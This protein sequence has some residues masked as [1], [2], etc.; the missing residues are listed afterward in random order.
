MKKLPEPLYVTRYGKAYVGD[1]LQLLDC[2]PD[3]FVDLVITSP[4][5]ALQR[6]KEYGNRD[7]DEYVDWFL[8]FAAKV[9]RVLKDT[10][11]FV[12]DLGGAYRKGRPV[13]SLYNYRVLLRLCDELGWNLA[14]EFFWFNP[15]KLPSPIEWVNK[16][17]IR[18]KDAVNTIWWLSKTDFPKADI[19]RVLVPYSDRMKRLLE[20]SDKYYSPKKRPSGHDISERFAEDRGGA[21][22]AN[23][24]QIPNTESNSQY[25]RCC[26]MVGVK[27]HPARFPQKL[28]QFFIQF[29]TD[30]GDT[31]LDIFAGSNTTGAAAEEL[32]RHW[33][34][35]EL[36]QSYLAAS[37]FR[38]MPEAEKEMARSL[39]ARLCV[40]GAANIVIPQV[41]QERLFDERAEYIAGTDAI[42]LSE[43][44]ANREDSTQ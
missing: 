20:N 44:P 3:Q 27:A 34:A 16:R 35:F 11:S 6:K 32:G 13:R 26:K 23:L 9:R 38:F 4:P 33:I 21:I 1:A 18:A 15:A 41:L 42:E 36:E 22:P 37:A 43:E 29:L 14:E 30:A 17:K 12:I 24:L 2:L 39:Y 31:V 19:T 40:E 5:F 8:W 25:L 10:G 7:Q 28:P